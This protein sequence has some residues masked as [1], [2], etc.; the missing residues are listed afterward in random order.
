MIGGTVTLTLGARTAANRLLRGR[1]G[2]FSRGFPALDVCVA[3]FA[4]L[5]LVVL[6]AHIRLYLPKSLLLVVAL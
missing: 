3:A 5:T 6:F 4:F 1:P 2:F